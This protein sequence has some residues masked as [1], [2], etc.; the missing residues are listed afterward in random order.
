MTFELYGYSYSSVIL[1]KELASSYSNLVYANAIKKVELGKGITVLGDNAFTCASL[2]SVT[3]PAEI[4]D[5]NRAFAAN[6]GIEYLVIT[7]AVSS[8]TTSALDDCAALKRVAFSETLLFISQYAFY[9]CLQ[10]QQMILTSRTRI[11]SGYTF[12]N[13][14]SLR[15]AIVNDCSS[16]GDSEFSNCVSLKEITIK[17]TA[18]WEISGSAFRS[19]ERLEKI[20]IPDCVIRIGS[21]AFGYCSALRSLKIPEG[22]TI[23]RSSLCYND[24]S[25]QEISI[26]VGV[27]SIENYAFYGCNGIENYYLYP[28][29]PPTLANKM[30]ISVSSNTKIHVPKGYLEAY[31]TAEVWSELADYMV[32]M[33]EENEETE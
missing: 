9:D 32:E 28:T 25:L 7:K 29:T 31:Q 18:L 20:E 3:I 15:R 4:T 19:C 17:G 6:K 11:G 16:V 27:T 13:N 23:I 21:Y 33:E 5:Y 1:H 12:S 8:L 30:A 10:L 26:P 22:V 14:R 2:T 24:Y